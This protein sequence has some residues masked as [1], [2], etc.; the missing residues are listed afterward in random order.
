MFN[1]NKTAGDSSSKATFNFNIGGGDK[2]STTGTTTTTAATENKS[3]PFGINT[4]P[5][6]DGGSS[7]FSLPKPGNKTE[8]NG[9]TTGL[10]LTGN[11]DTK[12]NTTGGG[13]NFA[14]NNK[15]STGGDNN[16]NKPQFNFSGG[17]NNTN[18]KDSGEQKNKKQF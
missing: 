17:N 11:T 16:A 8:N 10:N 14:F 18:N 6:A 4:K 9:G 13:L 3:S 5:A 2:S 7:A 12:T 15:A 1:M